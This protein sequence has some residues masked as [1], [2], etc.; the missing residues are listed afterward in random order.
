MQLDEVQPECVDR[1]KKS[2]ESR[3]LEN[4]NEEGFTRVR[5]KSSGLEVEPVGGISC[6]GDGRC[7][8]GRLVGNGG[9]RTS[10]NGGDDGLGDGEGEVTLG[11]G[12]EDETEEVGSR[13]RG[14]ESG[15][16][17]LETADLDERRGD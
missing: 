1:V 15:F 9:G 2:L 5:R 6:S 14:G 11:A 3:V 4:S 12:N 17:C 16:G 8:W 7:C 13:V 10:T